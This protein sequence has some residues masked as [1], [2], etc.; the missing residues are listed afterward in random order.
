MKKCIISGA[1]GLLGSYLVPLLSNEYEIYSLS[2][3]RNIKKYNINYVDIDLSKNWSI[4][5]LPQSVDLVIHL[6]Q[7]DN[8]NDFPKN[9]SQI[10]KINTESTLKLL[11]YSSLNKVSR[12][13]I[14]SSGGVYKESKKP[15]KETDLLTDKPNFYITSKICLELLAK[16]YKDLINISVIRPFFMYGLNQKKHML[17]P[18]L[19]NLIKEKKEIVLK[20]KNGVTINPIHAQ[21]AAKAVL[22]LISKKGIHTVNLGGSESI[23]LRDAIVMISS[24]LGIKSHIKIGNTESND[25]ILAN[26]DLM[27]KELYI[28]RIQFSKGI[29][30]VIKNKE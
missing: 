3:N 24:S 14:A 18:R 1:S 21:D 28:P 4:K 16:S 20:G 19:T 26:I 5:K 23:S 30:D 2:R 6:A 22:S 15:H 11:Q 29:L 13:I 17:F 10:F 7:S 9:A 12:V 8:Y 27:K 25:Y